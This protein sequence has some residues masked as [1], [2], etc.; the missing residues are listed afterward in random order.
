MS[1]SNFTEFNLQRNAYAAFDAVSMKQLITNRLKNSNLFSDISF[2]GSNISGVVDIVAYS[3]HVLLY[4]LNQTASETL[5]SQTELLENMNKLV[6]LI[7]YK[8]NGKLTAG[9]NV[10][11]NAS[12]ELPIGSYML[13]RFS[14]LTISGTSYSFNKDIPVNKTISAEQ[15]ISSI[16]D[17]N[18]LYQGLFKEYPQYTALGEDFEVITVNLNFDNTSTPNKFVDYNNIFV[19]VKDVNTQKWSEWTESNNLYLVNGY[20]K[21]YEKRF[22]AN[23]NIELKFGNDIN[24]K[25]LNLGDVI[26]IFYL[27]SDGELGIVGANT[28]N[29]AKMFNYS[30]S[31]IDE[32][33]MDVGSSNGYM[34]PSQVLQLKFTNSYE[35]IPNSD[36]ESVDE[37]RKNSP[38]LFS[39][40]NRVVSVFDYESS[41][42][43]YFS[44]IIQNV[45]VVSNKDYI[46]E[47]I[48]Y[49]YDL[50]L[51][52]PNLDDK[53]LFNQIS[54][55]DACDFNN[56][57]A[58]CVPKYG[59]ITDETTPN[60]LYYSQKQSIVNKLQP[61]KM[62]TNNIVISDPIYMA[63]NLG[64]N[65]LNEDI[66]TDIASNTYL[67]I[68]RESDLIISKE[69]IKT[70]V[71]QVI[72]DFFSQ[73]NNDLGGTIDLNKLN[74]DLLNIDGVKKIQ[75]YR[76]D[77]SYSVDKLSFL[78]WNPLHSDVDIS[79]TNQNI[80]LKYFQFPFYY[81]ISDL[82]NYIEVV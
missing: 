58:F 52:R 73:S 40:Q 41:I 25:S 19:Y 18:L 50:G 26:Q 61:L 65:Q 70:D 74:L 64:L 43:K 24:G 51:E 23:N 4:Y 15:F 42:S 35:S 54:F 12:S 77:I 39:A 46:D 69:K 34:S 7:A 29:S 66:T 59:A 81:K 71:F 5:F 45:K 68:I 33:L 14:Y 78:Y 63:F 62:I 11:V 22:N 79:I 67:R 48:K 38:L 49:Y 47:Y 36:A 60:Q 72:K 55:N 1:A 44:N 2:E 75:T 13:K 76:K 6:S 3:Y 80:V 10:S 30:S 27:E 8:P 17:N 56:V 20:S 9:L 53:F 57:Y 28:A 82:I 16:G 37:I 21:S 32:I 31:V